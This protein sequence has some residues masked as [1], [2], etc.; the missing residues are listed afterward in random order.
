MS[1]VGILYPDKD[2]KINIGNIDAPIVK[3]EEVSFLGSV[4]GRDKL[5]KVSVIIT[6]EMGIGDNRPITVSLAGNSIDASPI[7][8]YTEMGVF[9]GPLKTVSY[10]KASINRQNIYLHCLNGKGDVYYLGYSDKNLYH[11]SKDGMVE[12]LLT[13]NELMNGEDFRFNSTTPFLGGGVNPQ[14]TKAWISIAASSPTAYRFIEI[15]L[16]TKKVTT[17]NVSSSIEAPYQGNISDLQLTIAGVY[18]DSKGNVYLTIGN[19]TVIQAIALYNSNNR[20]LSYLYKTVKAASVSMPGKSLGI[21]QEYTG[22]KFIFNPEESCMYVQHSYVIATPNGGRNQIGYTLYN[23]PMQ[24]QLS[25]FKAS[26]ASERYIGS[27]AYFPS[28]FVS[29]YYGKLPLPGHRLVGLYGQDISNDK[30]P[31]WLELSFD[32]QRGIPYDAGKSEL[33]GHYFGP[34]KATSREDELLNYDE[35]NFLY[36]T[37]NGRSKLVKVAHNN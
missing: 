26:N 20:N 19:S 8:I 18:P 1:I 12:T 24:M 5:D 10:T 21:A 2:L 7:N 36:S 23:L 29:D 3:K 9:P 6:E 33:G 22:V 28:N 27:F 13:Q 37:A 25:N 4:G 34:N 30:L 31:I 16:Q 35:D 32:N 14:S 11:V 15:D 17:L